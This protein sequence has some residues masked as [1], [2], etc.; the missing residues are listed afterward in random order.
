MR[1][2]GRVDDALGMASALW[3]MWL[4]HGELTVG[5]AILTELLALPQASADL[6][7]RAKAMCV[8]GALAQALGDHE[9]A[10][11]L[12]RTA[13]AHLQT[14]GSARDEAFALNTLGLDAMQQGDYDES[15]RLL[16]ASLERFQTAGDRR[17][18]A[19]SMRHLSS[20]AYRH[21]HVARADD[22]AREGLAQLGEAA[23]RL[24]IARLLLNTSLMAIVQQHLQQA[25][26]MATRAL[27]LFQEDGDRWGEADALLRLGQVAHELGDLNLAAVHLEASLARFQDV[28][29]PEGTAK[30]LALLGWILRA[31]DNKA[32][33]RAHFDEAR[34]ICENLLQPSCT[35]WALLGAGTM[36]LDRG[37]LFVAGAAWKEALLLASD[38]NDHLIIAYALEWSSHLCIPDRALQRAR[39]LGAAAALRE[40]LPAPLGTPLLAEHEAIVGELRALLGAVTFDTGVE[41]GRMLPLSDAIA[42]AVDL[43]ESAATEDVTPPRLLAPDKYG[44]RVRSRGLS[45]REI[46]VLRLVAQGATDREIAEQLFISKR[47][48]ASHVANILRKLDVPS[49]AAASAE[50]VRSGLA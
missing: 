24:D 21:G 2:R 47:T 20:L 31:E 26:M 18:G 38:L 49:R 25:W 23:P 36:A 8:A 1:T 9:Q 3:P 50:A 5:R 6:S 14:L 29:D 33:A 10:V 27:T 32:E 30:V 37:E 42:I 17:A 4:E 34:A 39:M 45:L 40:A 12:S 46:Q 19:W 44:V 15:E 16:R 35:A 28:G 13:L 48:V 11:A 41:Q 22:L 7:A 43:L